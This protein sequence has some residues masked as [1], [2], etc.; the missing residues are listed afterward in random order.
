MRLDNLAANHLPPLQPTSIFGFIIQTR[1][2]S[3]SVRSLSYATV[4]T[5]R[6]ASTVGTFVTSKTIACSCCPLPPPFSVPGIISI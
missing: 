5:I 6:R 3:V 1:S 4:V 2:F